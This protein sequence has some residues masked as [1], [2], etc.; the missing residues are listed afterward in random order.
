MR[1]APWEKNGE[2]RLFSLVLTLVVPL[3]PAVLTAFACQECGRFDS[4]GSG[5]KGAEL[6]MRP[7]EMGVPCSTPIDPNS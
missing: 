2:K 1:F 3:F 7:L 5:P 6:S 4:L